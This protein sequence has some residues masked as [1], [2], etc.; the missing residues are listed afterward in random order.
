MANNERNT[1]ESPALAALR[2]AS[3]LATRTKTGQT[4]NLR[5]RHSR[6]ALAEATRELRDLSYVTFGRK[7]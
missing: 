3:R 2:E 5:L 4:Q 6:R 7:L 1:E